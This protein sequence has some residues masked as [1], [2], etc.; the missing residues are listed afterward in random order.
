MPYALYC[1]QMVY[2][3]W[4]TGKKIFDSNAA[5]KFLQSKVYFLPF[6]SMSNVVPLFVATKQKPIMSHPRILTELTLPQL[7][8]KLIPVHIS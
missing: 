4:N 3:S 6:R 2:T 8:T 7:S 1:G 5:T